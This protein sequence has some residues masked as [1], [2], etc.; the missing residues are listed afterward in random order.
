MSDTSGWTNPVTSSTITTWKSIAMSGN[1]QYQTAITVN[2]YIYTSIDS[3]TNWTDVFKYKNAWSAIAVSYTGQYQTA[4]VYQGPIYISCDYGQTWNAS[5]MGA[6]AWTSVCMSYT[7]QVQYATAAVNQVGVSIRVTASGN[8]GAIYVSSNYGVTWTACSLP[9][10]ILSGEWIQVDYINTSANVYDGA[11]TGSVQPS[12]NL[13]SITGY[14][15]TDPAYQLPEASIPPS[16]TLLG[17]NDKKNWYILDTVT[18]SHDLSNGGI[19]TWQNA[20]PPFNPNPIGLPKIF[21]DIHFTPVIPYRTT[22]RTLSN[23]PPFASFRL[24]MGSQVGITGIGGISF[25]GIGTFT[26]P[27]THYHSVAPNTELDFSGN[28]YDLQGPNHT[29]FS[30]NYTVISNNSLHA[31]VSWSWRTTSLKTMNQYV[32]FGYNFSEIPPAGIVCTPPISY[33]CLQN[34]I[35]V[36]TTLTKV[37]PLYSL[38]VKWT[39]IAMSSDARVILASYTDPMPESVPYGIMYYADQIAVS[40]PNMVLVKDNVNQGLQQFQFEPYGGIMLS[41]DYGSTWTPHY[42]FNSVSQPWTSVSMSAD[43]TKHYA[44]GPNGVWTN[45]LG[46]P[47]LVP[48]NLMG[49]TVTSVLCTSGDGFTTLVLFRN[50]LT[51]QGSLY[52]S[53]MRSNYATG[54]TGATGSALQLPFTTPWTGMALSYD[55]SVVSLCA[56]HQAIQTYLKRTPVVPAIGAWT[57]D[58]NTA[59]SWVSIAMAM[60]PLRSAVAANATSV[61]QTTDGS[62]WTKMVDLSAQQVCMSHDGQRVVA[63]SSSAVYLNDKTHSWTKIVTATP[64]QTLTNIALSTDLCGNVSSLI[65]VAYL[66]KVNGGMKQYNC[67]KGTLT[68]YTVAMPLT[69]N[70]TNQWTNLVVSDDGLVRIATLKSGVMYRSLNFDTSMCTLS[71]CTGWTLTGAKALQWADLAVSVDGR[72]QSAAATNE[73][74][75]Y[76]T[77]FGGTWSKSDAPLQLWKS[78]RM[79]YTGQYQTA[80][81]FNGLLYVSSNYGQ[82]WVIGPSQLVSQPWSAVVYSPDAAIIKASYTGGGIQT[83]VWTTKSTAVDCQYSPW[84]N[85]GPGRGDYEIMEQQRNIVAPALFGGLACDL[86]DRGGVLANPITINPQVCSTYSG[87]SELCPATCLFEYVLLQNSDGT[88]QC[89]NGFVQEEAS[90][91]QPG[92]SCPAAGNI[93]QSTTVCPI[94]V[95]AIQQSVGEALFT[96]PTVVSLSGKIPN[97]N[98]YTLTVAGV[99]NLQYGF[100]SA[101]GTTTA[102]VNLPDGFTYTYT[103]GVTINTYTGYNTGQIAMYKLPPT[104]IMSLTATQTTPVVGIVTMSLTT[105]DPSNVYQVRLIN[106]TQNYSIDTSGGFT[107]FTFNHQNI[108]SFPLNI[109]EPYS[110]TGGS[111]QPLSSSSSQILSNPATLTGKLDAAGN[112]LLTLTLGNVMQYGTYQ[113]IVT[114]TNPDGTCQSFTTL[115]M[116]QVPSGP[117]VST[118]PGTGTITFPITGNDPSTIYTLQVCDDTSTAPVCTVN[119]S[120]SGVFTSTNQ[121]VTCSLTGVQYNVGYHLQILA[122]T[123][124]G[125]FHFTPS[126]IPA[127]FTNPSVTTNGIGTAEIEFPLIATTHL[128]AYYLNIPLDNSNVNYTVVD[129]SGNVYTSTNGLNAC[130]LSSHCLS[131]AQMCIQ[132]DNY[133]NAVSNGH[134]TLLNGI[135][136]LASGFEPCLLPYFTP[137]AF[138]LTQLIPRIFTY[139]QFP[140]EEW[141]TIGLPLTIVNTSTR[142]LTLTWTMSGSDHIA[143]DLSYFSLPTTVLPATPTK[144]LLK[145]IQGFSGYGEDPLQFMSNFWT[146]LNINLSYGTNYITTQIQLPNPNSASAGSYIYSTVTNDLSNSLVVYYGYPL[147][148]P[149]TEPFY[150]I[151]GNGIFTV[152]NLT[153]GQPYPYQITAVMDDGTILTSGPQVVTCSLVSPTLP[154]IVV[155]QTDI[156]QVVVTFPI[157]QNEP[158]TKYALSLVMDNITTN[159]P[160]AYQ[161]IDETNQSHWC[162]VTNT[163]VSGTTNNLNCSAYQPSTW[164]G[165]YYSDMVNMVTTFTDPSGNVIPYTKDVSGNYSVNIS[166]SYYITANNTQLTPYT[167]VL[168][169]NGNILTYTISNGNYVF[170]TTSYGTLPTTSTGKNNTTS[171]SNTVGIDKTTYYKTSKGIILTLNTFPTIR[172]DL[173]GSIVTANAMTYTDLSLSSPTYVYTPNPCTFGTDP[174]CQVIQM[175]VSGSKP[176]TI[177]PLV[178]G[179]GTGTYVVTNLQ[180]VSYTFTLTATTQLLTAT[181]YSSIVVQKMPPYFQWPLIPNITQTTNGHVTITAQINDNLNQ[182]TFTP[183]STYYSLILFPANNPLVQYDCNRIVSDMDRLPF[184]QQGDAYYTVTVTTSFVKFDIYQLEYPPVVNINL[185][186]ANSFVNTSFNFN[187]NAVNRDGSYNISANSFVLTYPY[188]G[189]VNCI[190]TEYT[191]VSDNTVATCLAYAKGISTTEVRSKTILQQSAN[192]GVPCGILQATFPIKTDQCPFN[193]LS[194]VQGIGKQFIVQFDKNGLVY[195]QSSIT[196]S[197][198]VT[199]TIGTTNT[200]LPFPTL[201]YDYGTSKNIK[202]NTGGTGLLYSYGIVTIT[203][204]FNAFFKN[205]LYAGV[206][207]LT[208]ITLPI[209]NQIQI[210]NISQAS[211]ITGIGQV[212]SISISNI[213]V[214]VSIDTNVTYSY[215]VTFTRSDSYGTIS[216]NLVNKYMFPLSP[217]YINDTDTI[218]FDPQMLWY[219]PPSAVTSTNIITPNIITTIPKSASTVS[220]TRYIGGTDMK[221]WYHP[222]ITYNITNSNL[223]FLYGT[224]T[225]GTC[226]GIFNNNYI[227]LRSDSNNNYNES[228][229]RNTSFSDMDCPLPS[230]LKAICPSSTTTGTTSCNMDSVSSDTTNTLTRTSNGFTYQKFVWGDSNFSKSA[231]PLPY[232]V[233]DVTVALVIDDTYTTINTSVS[234]TSSSYRFTFANN[235]CDAGYYCPSNGYEAPCPTGSYCPLYSTTST[236]CPAGSYLTTIMGKSVGDCQTC[237]AGSYCPVKNSTPTTCPAGSYCPANGLTASILCPAGVGCTQTG[238]VVTTPIVTYAD[239]ISTATTTIYIGFTSDQYSGNTYYYTAIYN[240]SHTYKYPIINP[241]HTFMFPAAEVFNA[242]GGNCNHSFYITASSTINGTTYS[243][244]SNNSD[245]AAVTYFPFNYNTYDYTIGYDPQRPPGSSRGLVKSYTYGVSPTGGALILD[246]STAYTSTYTITINNLLLGPN[247]SNSFT[248]TSG[249]TFK[250]NSEAGGILFYFNTNG[251]FIKL[252]R[253]NAFSNASYTLAIANNGSYTGLYSPTPTSTYNFQNSLQQNTNFHIAFV[254]NGTTNKSKLFINGIQTAAT[255]GTP[256]EITWTSPLRVDSITLGNDYNGGTGLNYKF[257]GSVWETRLYNYCLDT[258]KIKALSNYALNGTIW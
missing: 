35:S 227:V 4:L 106:Q 234:A 23:L 195:D 71:G 236:P 33:L 26:P 54:A 126:S 146:S 108:T 145:P 167:A 64:S 84:I 20:T 251:E 79:S 118:G 256:D 75:Y 34:E 193:S 18:D 104:T 40:N 189:A 185:G 86:L 48:S 13:Y 168:D 172:Y 216:G 221:S 46:Q 252:M 6:Q 237:P 211:P 9:T 8:E 176:I 136:N 132:T 63:M 121:V 10:S 5:S 250:E 222:L 242:V 208:P 44:S 76:S 198:T 92:K 130:D 179:N 110:A 62:K 141:M 199:K 101:N 181:A 245:G 96:F 81:A 183:P 42:S 241:Q 87:V 94:V 135:T 36:S 197:G 151:N 24:V 187:I 231:Y 248:F 160:F 51:Q 155:T 158:F 14:T 210:G 212:I 55:A 52:V 217:A 129:G 229:W 39:S 166:G 49:D 139:Q 147:Q 215:L 246:K 207:P 113:C 182:S 213:P 2:G 32:P 19:L 124:A 253:N 58:T 123:I 128:V 240:V 174:T 78:V 95:T 220:T 56:S 200:I 1:G 21:T 249:F 30:P 115:Y 169:I 177:Q 143:F 175:N 73:G 66:D 28:V 144:V 11:P 239:Y 90:I 119:K 223:K 148:T 257:I 25:Q 127:S 244:V 29:Q 83:Y 99:S 3:G 140:M 122:N 165:D 72:Y 37:S 114:T 88:L 255:N 142:P 22:T 45:G 238:T 149:S 131:G 85:I 93:E 107:N 137:N 225:T 180:P 68:S 154:S 15:I 186:P 226:E 150:K 41:T 105:Q 102:I 170:T 80:I 91:L 133:G 184:S 109:P 201:Q 191:P 178:I 50:D 98:E 89:A 7:G 161:W 60:P 67:T 70:T 12:A 100:T 59:G 27:A 196:L 157:V 120:I 233:Y 153:D 103:I 192:G 82:N 65:D 258:P 77:S 116:N 125:D 152:H 156:G 74:I 138:Q 254:Y 188:T 190:T 69:N 43:G 16:W 219:V 164:S 235:M 194:I 209:N 162:T 53:S 57:M 111:T 38:S 163:S 218:T 205:N 243:S 203:Y 173:S 117:F 61:Y 228:V 224:E 17:S 204:Q 171:T 112:V 230:K 247:Y 214:N 31:T 232:G 202:I 134:Y 47:I 97:I 206:Y 159:S